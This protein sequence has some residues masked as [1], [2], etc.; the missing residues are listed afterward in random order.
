[1]KTIAVIYNEALVPVTAI[2]N[3]TSNK[4]EFEISENPQLKS[5]LEFEVVLFF[6]HLLTEI[7]NN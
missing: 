7:R 5:E 1:M 3:L 6:Y 4:F 2:V